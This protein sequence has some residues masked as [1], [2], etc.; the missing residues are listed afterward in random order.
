MKINQQNY[1]EVIE[2]TKSYDTIEYKNISFQITKTLNGSNF[3]LKNNNL[4]FFLTL[5]VIIVINLFLGFIL[6]R[7]NSNGSFFILGGLVI[8]YFARKISMYFTEKIH[9]KQILEFFEILKLYK[10]KQIAEK[11]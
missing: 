3:K 7:N 5:V 1:Y 9:S 2:N 10:Q 4:I 11:K 8:L 6:T